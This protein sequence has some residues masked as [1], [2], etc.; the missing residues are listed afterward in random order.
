MKDSGYPEGANGPFT[1]YDGFRSDSV[2]CASAQLRA[3]LFKRLFVVGVHS[4]FHGVT[5]L[6]DGIRSLIYRGVGRMGLRL[7]NCP[8]RFGDRSL[9]LGE[10]ALRLHAG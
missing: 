4:G 3:C 7:V 10:W 8:R 9:S 2:S 5:G 6:L 1:N